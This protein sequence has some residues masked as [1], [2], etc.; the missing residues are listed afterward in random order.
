METKKYID[1]FAETKL[2][3]QMM[4]ITPDDLGYVRRNYNVPNATDYET[5]NTDGEFFY[6]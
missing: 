4:H 3:L 6:L 5:V 2:Q 1:M